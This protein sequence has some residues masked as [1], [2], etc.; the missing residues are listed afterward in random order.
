M[1]G[2]CHVHL[3]VSLWQARADREKQEQ[4]TFHLTSGRTSLPYQ[5]PH[6]P[7]PPAVISF[8]LKHA[9][10]AYISDKQRGMQSAH[11]QH[12]P[13]HSP[14]SQILKLPFMFPPL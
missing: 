13:K 5:K 14:L 2:R 12:G 6:V 1:G 4:L 9:E 8:R 3:E 10:N 7:V 11:T